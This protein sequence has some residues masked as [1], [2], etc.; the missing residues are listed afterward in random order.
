MMIRRVISLL[1]II[2]WAIPARGGVEV[3]FPLQGSYRPGR[4]MPVRIR[5]TF[6]NAGAGATMELGADG[7]M[8][9]RLMLVAGRAEGMVPLLPGETLRQV[10]WQFKPG[11]SGQKQSGLIEQAFRALGPEQALVGFTSIDMD[12]AHAL[13]KDKSIVPIRLDAADPLAGTPV[14]W[15]TLNAVVLDAGARVDPSKIESLLAT[16]VT[17]AIRGPTRP[18][19]RLP[20]RTMGGY[21]V[22]GQPIAGPTTAG[23]SAAAFLPVLSWEADWPAAFRRRILLYAVVFS[24]LAMGVSLLRMRWS[25]LLVVGLSITFTLGLWA[26]WRGRSAVLQRSGEIL[27]LSEKLAQSDKWTYLAATSTTAATEPWTEIVHPFFESSAAR[28]AMKP[29]LVCG[30]NGEPRMFQFQLGPGLKMGFLSRSFLPSPPAQ[31]RQTT[32]SPLELLAR[33]MYLSRGDTIAGQIAGDESDTT[34]ERWGTVVI[35]RQEGKV[36][37]KGQ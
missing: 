28:L 1:V 35:E 22:A 15:E 21:W 14:A 16:G 6:E 18:D 13:F 31:P 19:D 33:Q 5:A 9:T 23:E 12:I 8:N 26:W 37:A 25:A 7:A 27:V 34:R 11:G 24:V 2:L 36:S 3:S 17:V 20:W 10:H 4:Y 30:E 32:N 29:V